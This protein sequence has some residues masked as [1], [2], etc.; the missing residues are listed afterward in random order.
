LRDALRA[1]NGRLGD[2]E[3]GEWRTECDARFATSAID[4]VGAMLAVKQA[5]AGESLTTR[6]IV[7]RRAMDETAVETAAALGIEPA[8]VR[9][10]LARFIRRN[11]DLAAA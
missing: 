3:M 9:Q 4:S 11:I 8:A 1:R 7:L 10:R 5:L 6:E 2:H